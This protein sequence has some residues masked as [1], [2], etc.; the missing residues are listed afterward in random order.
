M[1]RALL[2]SQDT[3]LGNNSTP[4][5]LHRYLYA[6]NNPTV[7]VD[8][9]GNAATPFI[10]KP[11]DNTT[12]QL[13]LVGTIDT[14]NQAV[15]VTLASVASVSNAV[16]SMGN[17]VLA[18]ANAPLKTASVISGVSQNEI[19][20]TATGMI[21][22]SGPAAPLVFAG[23]LPMMPGMMLNKVK[24]LV[25]RSKSLNKPGNTPDVSNANRASSDGLED[26]PVVQEPKADIRITAE[27]GNVSSAGNGVSDKSSV[28]KTNNSQRPAGSVRKQD[29]P[30]GYRKG[31]KAKHEAKAKDETGQ[32]R[33]Q[34]RGCDVPEGRPLKTGEGTVE[35]NPSLVQTH[36][37]TGYNV[38]QP[39]RNDLYN[40]TTSGIHCTVCQSRQGGQTKDRYRRDV[41]PDYKP[42][43]K[44]KKK[45][46]NNT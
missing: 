44:R 12:L 40:D 2:L 26:I 10:S 22:S 7:F 13:P 34:D 8:I 27:N 32:I 35:H 6:Y 29:Y 19:S 45:E 20:N 39:T 31:V 4:P 14:G 36:N 43:P 46:E 1:A 42:K 3:Y 11:I 18:G 38:D 28:G 37:E 16:M 24:Q 17:A 21:A 33:C 15:D 41:G 30:S 5:S 25:Q 23:E 9:N